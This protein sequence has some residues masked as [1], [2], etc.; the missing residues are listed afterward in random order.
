MNQNATGRGPMAGWRRAGAGIA[1]A[2]VTAGTLAGCGI[3]RTVQKVA[4]TVHANK[5][6]IDE[7]T[8]K[9]KSGQARALTKPEIGRLRRAA[10]RAAAP[11]IPEA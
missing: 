3:A 8:G 6:T 7:F 11:E 5:A 1:V 4:D 10:E 2:L 9:L